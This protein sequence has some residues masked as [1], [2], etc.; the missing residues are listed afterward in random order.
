[1]RHRCRSRR[2]GGGSNLYSN[3]KTLFLNTIAFLAGAP[4]YLPPPPTGG[5]QYVGPAG[6]FSTLVKNADGTY[7]RTLKDGAKFQFDAQGLQTAVTD[8]NNNTT[9]YAYNGQGRLATITDPAGQVTTFTYSG[10]VLTSLTDPAGRI[11]QLA[12]DSDGNLT[13]VT[14]ADATQ[15]TFTYDPQRRLTQR[16]DAQSKV[17][18]YQYDYAGRFSQA[19][20]PTGETRTLSPSQKLAV[21]NTA[22]GQGTQSNPAPLAAPVNAASFTDAN[23]RTTSFEL[24][25]NL[26]VTKQT[27]ALN[28]TTNI[29]RDAKASSINKLYTI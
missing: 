18:Q 10:S 1:L 13:G 26:G 2:A 3:N 5:S 11:T 7:T 4:G 29:V 15:E 9:T 21:P 28:C 19:T 12:H 17:Y 24:D 14:Y 6:D 27:D 8:R 20:L 16:T 25:A 22:A 23:N